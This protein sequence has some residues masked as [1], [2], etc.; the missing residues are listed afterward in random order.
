MTVLLTPTPV[1]LGLSWVSERPDSS[2]FAFRNKKKYAGV[3][4]G[5]K[6]GSVIRGMALAVNRFLAAAS[7]KTGALSQP[8]ISVKNG[9]DGQII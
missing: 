6:G 4:F 5:K 3:K 9:H 1:F 8:Q 7:E 2:S